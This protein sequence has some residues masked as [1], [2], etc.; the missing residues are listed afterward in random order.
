M[1]VNVHAFMVEWDK[2]AARWSEWQGPNEAFAD[3]RP[4][5]LRDSSCKPHYGAIDLLEDV[6]AAASLRALCQLV[7]GDYPSR[8]DDL[9]VADAFGL[10]KFEHA[11]SPASVATWERRLASPT[12]AEIEALLRAKGEDDGNVQLIRE[13]HDQWLR[14]FGEL[15]AKGRGLVMAIG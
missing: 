14:V 4:V 3:A 10:D 9:G 12:P 1:S 2:L 13:L 15:S 5:S 7:S 11:F 8:V 6:P